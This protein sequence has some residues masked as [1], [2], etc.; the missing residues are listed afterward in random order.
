MFQYALEVE[1]NIVDSGKINHRV[2]KRKIKEYG[3]S[4]FVASSNNLRFEMMMKIVEKI[5][6]RMT[7]DNILLHKEKK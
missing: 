5:M 1:S 7:V 4:T 3:P 6:D 2:E